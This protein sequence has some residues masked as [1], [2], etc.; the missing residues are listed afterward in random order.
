MYKLSKIQNHFKRDNLFFVCTT[1]TTT[2][3]IQ[4]I[5]KL[6]KLNLKS[7]KLYKTL[8]QQVFKNSI[9]GNQKFLI[10]GLITLMI[11]ETTLTLDTLSQLNKIMTVIGVKINNKIYS[12]N[13]LNSLIELKYS[14]GS[15]DLLKTM[16]I[17]LKPLKIV[18]C[19]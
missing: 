3:S 10:N 7:S 2:N 16:K 5:Q 1:R 11:P 4:T 9:Y 6:K 13:Q 18:N 19:N 12:I 8:T 17:C 15:A 14:H